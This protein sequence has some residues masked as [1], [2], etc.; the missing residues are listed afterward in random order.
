M[1]QY[2]MTAEEYRGYTVDGAKNT[3]LEAWEAKDKVLAI[4]ALPSTVKNAVKATKDFANG[5]PFDTSIRFAAGN[6]ERRQAQNAAG[7]AVEE[8]AEKILNKEIEFP[9][10]RGNIRHINKHN[11]ESVKQQLVHGKLTDEQLAIKLEGSFFNP[12][13]TTEDINKYA[14]EAYNA[15]KK[16]GKT[17][18]LTYEINGEI[19]DVFIHPNGNFGTV[20]GRYRFTV[21]EVKNMIK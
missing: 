10:S 3:I 6:D 18:N 15:L 17:G 14:E 11:I 19:L 4:L 5:V 7:D 13:W 16:Q 9:L 20:H 12:N 2:G 8:A 21:E 1:E